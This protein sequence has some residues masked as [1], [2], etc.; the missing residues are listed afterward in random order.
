MISVVKKFGYDF[1]TLCICLNGLLRLKT[2][3][4]FLIPSLLRSNKRWTA[5]AKEG[6]RA[7]RRWWLWWGA[8]LLPFC[9]HFVRRLRNGA[10]RG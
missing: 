6:W 5:S 8:G 4:Q 10:S 7:S 3:V 1:Q 2:S 9:V